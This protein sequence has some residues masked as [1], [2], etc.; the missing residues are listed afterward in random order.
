M[1]QHI[2]CT[3]NYRYNFLQVMKQYYSI[4]IIGWGL[5]LHRVLVEVGFQPSDLEVLGTTQSDNRK[6]FIQYGYGVM[7]VQCQRITRKTK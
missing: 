7:S 1:T 6:S 2:T 5:Y 3:I 4:V